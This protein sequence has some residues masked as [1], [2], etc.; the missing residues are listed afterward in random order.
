MNQFHRTW[1]FLSVFKIENLTV[2]INSR[3]ESYTS[4]LGQLKKTT[5]L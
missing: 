5:Y 1:M 2:H 4:F 3:V